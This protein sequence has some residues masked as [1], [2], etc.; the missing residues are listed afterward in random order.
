MFNKHKYNNKNEFKQSNYENII[1]YNKIKVK[2][3]T[4]E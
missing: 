4:K 2:I 3:D 1:N